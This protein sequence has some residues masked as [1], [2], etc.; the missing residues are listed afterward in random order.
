MEQGQA[1]PGLDGYHGYWNSA[2]K[3]G[4]SGTA[5]FTK[6]PPL[7]VSLGMGIEEH[8]T[9]GRMITLDYESFT[10][11]CA[12]TPNAQ[13]ELTRLPYRM[14]WEDDFRAYLLELDMKKPVIVCGDL[15]VAHEEI[16]IKNA[17]SNRGNAGFTDEERSKMSILL[18]AGFSDTFRKLYPDKT[19]AYTWW[20]YMANVRERNIG[21]RIDYFL[22][23]DR[24]MPNVRDAVI[25][26]DIHGSDHCPVGLIIE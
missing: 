25:Y 23:S 6:I 26:P 14:Q 7:S 3:K 17:K 24:L 16:D 5:I 18:K 1:D 15:N 11:V 10:L 4:Y 9:E 19:G 8:D 20:S 12:Y 22:V 2:A 13:R 21:W